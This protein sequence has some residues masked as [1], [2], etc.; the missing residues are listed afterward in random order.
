MYKL[1]ANCNDALGGAKEERPTPNAFASGRPI[2]KA[3]FSAGDLLH[4]SFEA[5]VTSKV[6]QQRISREEEQ[7]AFIPSRIGMLERFN[8]ASFFA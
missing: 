3:L 4:Q 2:R 5:R 8:S 7:V 6:V 1:N